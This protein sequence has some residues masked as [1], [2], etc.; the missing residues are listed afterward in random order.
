MTDLV[1]V[2]I[3][4]FNYGRYIDQALE[5]VRRQSHV[6]WECIV[7][8]D[9]STDDT[10]ERIEKW[11]EF[12]SR[13]K[14]IRQG[15][16]GV[17]AARNNGLKNSR[18]RFIQFLD[19]DDLL[20]EFKI[21]RQLVFLNAHP[22]TDI[23]YGRAKSIGPDDIY[24]TGSF[25]NTADIDWLPEIR[26]DDAL[27]SLV[28]SPFP[29]HCALVRRSVIDD[30]GLFDESKRYCE[31]WYYWIQCAAAGKRFR[32]EDIEGT[33]AYYRT[34]SGS[35]CANHEL[36]IAGQRRL[37]REINGIIRDPDI[38]KLNRSLAASLEGYQGI[39]KVRDGDIVSGVVDCLKAGMISPTFSER[40]K[41]FYCAAVSPFARRGDIEHVVTLPIS[42]S[43]RSIL[44]SKG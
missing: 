29:T 18:G 8:D 26:G 32:Y 19:A 27:R 43:F 16:R 34:H 23:V 10:R 14:D 24:D 30:I 38:R 20:D 37:R 36:N 12:D 21:E 35:A 44:R 41:W 9:G 17:S 5:S 39:G 42:Q 33:V 6:E 13:F 1:S 22:V 3:P 4:T 7:V 11:T 31:D 2:I 28:R 25:E 40:L 15:N